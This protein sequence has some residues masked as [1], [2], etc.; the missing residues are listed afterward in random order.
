[1]NRVALPANCDEASL[2]ASRQDDIAGAL[3]LALGRR[4]ARPWEASFPQLHPPAGEF[5]THLPLRAG[6][7]STVPP[8]QCGNGRSVV[9]AQRGKS[10][11]H[12]GPI[13]TVASGTGRR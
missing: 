10:A 9:P 6:N 8:R 12:N 5:V 13:N 2:D 7:L 3:I 4:Q 11:A 1:M